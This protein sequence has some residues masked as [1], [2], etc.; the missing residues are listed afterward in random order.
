MAPLSGLAGALERMRRETSP[1]TGPRPSSPALV[2]FGRFAAP[3]FLPPAVW[4]DL[5]GLPKES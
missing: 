3:F 1:A 4:P 5:V 2:F